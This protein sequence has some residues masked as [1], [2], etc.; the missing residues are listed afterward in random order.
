M[1]MRN[2]DFSPLYRSTVGFEHLSSMLNDIHRSD[3]NAASYPPYNIELLGENQYQITVAIS[4]FQMSDLTINIEN[5][6]LSIIGQKFDK[7]EARKFLHQG[8]AG[9]DFDRRFQLAE[10]V[11]VKDAAFA[12]GLLYIDLVREIPDSMKPKSVPIRERNNVLSDV[13]RRDVA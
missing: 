8:I 5:Q 6:I 13:S 4:G 3:T 7:K 9:R 12:D 2:L 1:N 10:H 11:K